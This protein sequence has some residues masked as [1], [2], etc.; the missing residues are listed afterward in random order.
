MSESIA[1]R[2]CWRQNWE[3]LRSVSGKLGKW[4][5]LSEGLPCWVRCFSTVCCHRTLR[6]RTPCG[7]PAKPLASAPRCVYFQL[8]C[9]AKIS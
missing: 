8:P 5:P 6:L 1:Q 4:Q 2:T 3:Q 7:E 9:R